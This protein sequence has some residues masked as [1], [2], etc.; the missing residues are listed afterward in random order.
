LLIDLHCHTW[1]LSDD[2]FLSPDALIEGAK[3]AGLDGVCLTEHDFPWD[4]RK[5]EE[6]REKHNFLVIAGM[7]INTEDGHIVVFGLHRYVYGMHRVKELARMV[8]EANGAM[9]AAHPYRR[10]MPFHVRDEAEYEAAL[11]RVAKNPAYAYVHGMEEING[12]GSGPEN[13]F[14]R[15]L[16]ALLKLPGSAGSDSHALGDIG[17]CATFFERDIK[18]ESD[19][20]RELRAGRFHPVDL[21]VKIG[22]GPNQAV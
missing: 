14:S 16:R 15:R 17:R 20:I 1:P 18:D 5:V 22:E 3:A 8:E 19:L 6:L 13:D 21:R 7:E 12:R 4:P 10:Q 2:S 11:A 9:I